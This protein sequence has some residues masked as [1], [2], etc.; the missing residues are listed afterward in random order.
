MDCCYKVLLGAPVLCTVAALLD[1]TNLETDFVVK[2]LVLAIRFLLS[3][4]FP[5][6]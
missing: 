1:L 6:H 5:A 4:R 3:I 2:L